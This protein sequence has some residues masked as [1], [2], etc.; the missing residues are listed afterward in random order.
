[1]TQ[2]GPLHI[3][4]TTVSYSLYLLYSQQEWGYA[5][6]VNV[7]IFV[8]GAL[9]VAVVWTLGQGRRRA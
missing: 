4:E 3:S 7:L 2:G 5:S 1:M 9:A 8:F 6:A